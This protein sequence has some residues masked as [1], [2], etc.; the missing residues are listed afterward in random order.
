MIKAVA[1][2]LDGTLIDSTD[3]IVESFF[4]TFEALGEPPP[5]RHAVVDSIGY[6]LED[7]FA[8]LTNRDPN[9]CVRV[10]RAH[11]ATIACEKTQ[12]LPGAEESLQRLKDAGLRIGFATSKKRTYA[13]MILD[14]MGL[15]GFFETRL[16]PHDVTHPKPH[17]EA[18]LKSLEGLQ[19][20][21]DEMFFV[22][23]TDF[24]VLAAM[25]A[26][27]RCLCVTTGYDTREKLVALAPEA[28]MDSLTEV[29]DYILA[30]RNR[31]RTSEGTS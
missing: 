26:N 16:G 15:L 21:N 30:H 6:T 19:V 24:D 18:V 14:D 7:Q 25:E 2:D 20:T 10:Y 23:D 5:L 22:G 27:V 17:P 31:R 9:E 3:A 29:T 12:P 1:F 13:E 11:Y 28:V 8:R 4:H